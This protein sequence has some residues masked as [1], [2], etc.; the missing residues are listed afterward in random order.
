[1]RPSGLHNRHE[2]ELAGADPVLI[3]VD[4]AEA[5]LRKEMDGTTAALLRRQRQRQLAFGRE[6][7]VV[8]SRVDQCMEELLKGVEGVVPPCVLDPPVFMEGPSSLPGAP[9]QGGEKCVTREAAVLPQAALSSPDRGKKVPVS[10]GGGDGKMRGTAEELTAPQV[11]GVLRGGK[12]APLRGFPLPFEDSGFQCPTLWAETSLQEVLLTALGPRSLRERRDQDEPNG[13]LLVGVACYLLNEILIR[14]PKLSRVWPQLREVIF[15]AVF[16]PPASPPASGCEGGVGSSYPCFEGRQPFEMLHLWAGAF[17]ASRAETARLA[18]RIEELKGV[19]QKSR[20]ILRFAQRRVD[21]MLLGNVFRAWRKTTQRE[22]CFRDSAMAYFTRMRQRIRVEGCF[23]RWRRVSAHSQVVEL[24]KMVK[25]SEV[26][27]AFLQSSNTKEVAALSELLKREQK[28]NAIL[29]MKKEALKSQLAE[30]HVIA[31]RAIDNELQQQHTNILMAKKCGKRWERLAK[32]FSCRAKCAVVPSSLRKAGIALRRAEEQYALRTHAV[33]DQG[34]QARHALECF[35]L[36]WV[37]C[38]MKAAMPGVHWRRVVKIDTGLENGDFGPEALLQLVRVLESVYLG[39]GVHSVLY[40]FLAA[41]QEEAGELSKVNNDTGLSVETANG[42]LFTELRRLLYLQSMEGLYPPL[43]SCCTFLESFFTPA[44]FCQTPHPSAM[45]WV[46]ASLFVGYARL[47]CG[48]PVVLEHDVDATLRCQ[49]E[50]ALRNYFLMPRSVV[51]EPAAAAE[52][53]KEDTGA[54]RRISRTHVVSNNTTIQKHQ[55]PR[56]CRGDYIRKKPE[57]AMDE[58]TSKDMERLADTISD[59]ELY[60]GLDD[61]EDDESD[62]GGSS[63][64]SSVACGISEG[65]GTEPSTAHASL[66]MHVETSKQETNT[67][68]EERLRRVNRKAHLVPPIETCMCSFSLREFVEYHNRVAKRR[69]IWM[70]LSRVVSSLV[71]RFRLLDVGAPVP[72]VVKSPTRRK[73]S[74]LRMGTPPITLP[75]RSVSVHQSR[76]F[77]RLLPLSS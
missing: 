53:E 39:S 36:D 9:Q 58:K 64:E 33:H 20:L 8:R 68:D 55:R 5:Q 25:E 34:K 42:T 11:H 51:N 2:Q 77:I 61:Q 46:L 52:A 3:S 19:V 17:L 71:V 1:M 62:S 67:V 22:R 56:Q 48:G 37:N 29:E 30:G 27:Q 76:K 72:E 45:L 4:R 13:R 63:E 16:Q 41:R 49:E 47:A 73:K 38:F 7:A 70:G 12:S 21:K 57:E 44:V 35:L 74:S 31:L 50:G 14:E 23:L 59:L 6:R 28:L 32:T 69:R 75:N 60:L 54:G 18:H 40:P 15:K 43:L 66:V 26:R 65:R 24:Q 10:Y